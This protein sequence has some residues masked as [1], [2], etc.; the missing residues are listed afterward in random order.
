MKA[1]AK[2][3]LVLISAKLKESQY[4]AIRNMA[5]TQDISFAG[6]LRQIVEDWIN[7]TKL[8]L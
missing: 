6:Q 2:N 8:K 1:K 5:R 4:L 3:G 7:S